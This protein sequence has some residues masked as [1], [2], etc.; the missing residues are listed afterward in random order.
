MI[1]WNNMVYDVLYAGL[2]REAFGFGVYGVELFVGY[3]RRAREY[4]TN[5]VGTS[6]VF[7]EPIG[8][9][10]S[11]QPKPKRGGVELLEA[12]RRGLLCRR[13]PI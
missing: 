12:Q 13:P 4:P 8:L 7:L 5:N 6:R 1:D 10:P 11:N 2:D 9:N 3:P